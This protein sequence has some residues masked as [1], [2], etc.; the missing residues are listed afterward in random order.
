MAAG[1]PGEPT[2]GSDLVYLRARYLNPEMG[3]FPSL[4]PFEGVIQRAMSLN[5]Y[6][7]VEGQVP[8]AVDPSGRCRLCHMRADE[9]SDRSIELFDDAT[10]F[11]KGLARY[12]NRARER[13][14]QL[15]R[16]YNLWRLANYNDCTDPEGYPGYH[17]LTYQDVLAAAIG[18]EFHTIRNIPPIYSNAIEALGRWYFDERNSGVETY[19]GPDGICQGIQL[20]LLL[21]SWEGWFSANNHITVAQLMEFMQDEGF[22]E[23]AQ[24]ILTNTVVDSH[25]ST[26]DVTTGIVGV[27]P[28]NWGNFSLLP[29]RAIS[30][31]ENALNNRTLT[32]N[33]SWEGVYYR[34]ENVYRYHIWG[35][36]NGVSSAN[37]FV[38]W[39]LA[40]EACLKRPGI[41]EDDTGENAPPPTQ[42][43]GGHP[44]RVCERLEDG[45]SASGCTP[46]E[47][48]NFD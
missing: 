3:V 6:S 23:S 1:R 46:G 21:G 8:N 12:P 26:Q 4:D 41:D 16:R 17:Y 43:N 39:S 14:Y 11:Y 33:S 20:W 24:T 29:P 37:P 32:T 48:Y 40:Q 15:E 30:R 2:D 9:F 13:F 44:C 36:D 25:R 19:C 38:V 34:N 47:Y 35:F 10:E 22:R 42:S 45:P 5:G 7:W 27:R 18:A 31:L 28:V